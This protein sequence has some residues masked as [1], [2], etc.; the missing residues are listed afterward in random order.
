MVNHKEQKADSLKEQCGLA[1]E[2]ITKTV[3]SRVSLDNFSCIFIAFNNYEKLFSYSIHT[4]DNS[5]LK[6][7][8]IDTDFHPQRKSIHDET[9]KTLDIKELELDLSPS[10]KTNQ[11]IRSA[12]IKTSKFKDSSNTKIR[13]FSSI[14]KKSLNS[15][16][17]APSSKNDVFSL[18]SLKKLSFNFSDQNNK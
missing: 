12:L 3:I 16:F 18:S 13:N 1:V 10:K 14:N 5:T 17:N 15:N 9:A 8:L 11:S 7:I 2:M 6:K 4:I